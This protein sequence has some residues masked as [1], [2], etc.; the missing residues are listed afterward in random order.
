MHGDGPVRPVDHD[1]GQLVLALVG[2]RVEAVDGL[3]LEDRRRA[4]GLFHV[5][6]HPAPHVAELADKL[7]ALAVER[8]LAELLGAAL[9]LEEAV[10]RAH[11]A[12]GGEA[13]R[14]VFL[15]LREGLP[16]DRLESPLLP[17]PGVHVI[18]LDVRA[19]RSVPA[20]GVEHP[21]AR[22]LRVE[23]E[24]LDVLRRGAGPLL[25]LRRGLR[26]PQLP[27]VGVVGVGLDLGGVRVLRVRHVEAEAEQDGRHDGQRAPL[28]VVV[29][30]VAVVGRLVPDLQ[31]PRHRARV[32][33]VSL[34]VEVAPE[35]VADLVHAVGDGLPRRGRALLERHAAQLRVIGEVDVLGPVPAEARLVDA[36]V[37][38]VRGRRRRF[39]RPKLV[40]ERH[41]AEGVLDLG[42][43]LQVRE[44]GP[45]LLAV[46]RLMERV[47]EPRGLDARRRGERPAEPLDLRHHARPG[48]VDGA[49]VE[50]LPLRPVAVVELDLRPVLELALLD[51]E[52]R[53]ALG[54]AVDV[55]AP[56]PLLLV[57]GP[58]VLAEELLPGRVVVVPDL[59]L[60]LRLDLAAGVVQRERH[61]GRR[62]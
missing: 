33:H 8:R 9:V 53:A 49:E 25:D 28:R 31:P 15:V 29:D 19:Q 7:P 21:P 51:V 45:G 58:G 24:V 18:D 35:P 17:V 16:A 20:V 40:A 55:V 32:A 41:A 44:A 1:G 4:R 52:H 38:H 3:V 61:V 46:L 27:G 23:P 50:D 34:D 43:G 54:A 62:P 6:G 13:I 5:V 42:A 11:E 48:A 60:V 26:D 47:P 10:A 30:D 39:L 2:R 37:E 14:Q 12:G 22:E 36:R 57:H 59:H 56:Q